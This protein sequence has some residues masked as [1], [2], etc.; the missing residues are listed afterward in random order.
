MH[1]ESYLY[2]GEPC[3]DGMHRPHGGEVLYYG[4][5]GYCAAEVG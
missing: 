5:E 4:K 2:E 1:G 3:L